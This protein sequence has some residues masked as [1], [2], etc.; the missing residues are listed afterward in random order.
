MKREELFHGKDITDNNESKGSSDTYK[1]L[2]KQPIFSKFRVT[3]DS[4]MFNHNGD[5][6]LNMIPIHQD[7]GVTHTIQE[8]IFMRDKDLNFVKKEWDV[9]TI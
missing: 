2:S 5:I 8:H 1:D 4:R 7:D 6:L 9:A 3:N